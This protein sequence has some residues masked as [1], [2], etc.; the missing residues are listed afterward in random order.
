M[1]TVIILLTLATEH[2]GTFQNK[3]FLQIKLKKSFFQ[4]SLESMFP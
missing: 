1:S 2:A 3:D 4:K